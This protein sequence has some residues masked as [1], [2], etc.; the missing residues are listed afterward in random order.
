MPAGGA[1]Y[2]A[3]DQEDEDDAELA[4]ALP[5]PS[6]LGEVGLGRIVALHH[7]SCTSHQI[8]EEIRCLYF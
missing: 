1:G 5:A 2:G 3:L 7:R 4:A 6:A 8:R